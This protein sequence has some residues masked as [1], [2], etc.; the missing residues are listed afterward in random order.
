VKL[1]PKRDIT[2][3]LAD[4]VR[5]KGHSFGAYYSLLDW[6]HP[7]YPDAA[8]LTDPGERIRRFGQDDHVRMYGRDYPERLAAAGFTVTRDTFARA[9]AP[10]ARSRAGVDPTE[11]LWICERP[12]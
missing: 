8:A 12:A 11:D 7:E 5:A 10:D 2:R 4:A 6:H 3:E 9:L 1:G